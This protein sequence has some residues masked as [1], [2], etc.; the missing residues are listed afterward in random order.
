MPKELDAEVAMI[1]VES[2]HNAILQIPFEL[3]TR[4]LCVSA[5]SRYG[6]HFDRI[7]DKFRDKALRDEARKIFEKRRY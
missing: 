4:E 1:A 3:I 2:D 5:V 6:P 7:P